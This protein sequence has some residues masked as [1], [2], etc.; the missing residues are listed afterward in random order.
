VAVGSYQCHEDSSRW[1]EK[2]ISAEEMFK[3]IKEGSGKHYF[4]KVSTPA[5]WPGEGKKSLAGFS[6]FNI[7]VLSEIS[8]WHEIMTDLVL[9]MLPEHYGSRLFLTGFADKNFLSPE[10][11]YHNA[12]FNLSREIRAGPCLV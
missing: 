1:P 10:Q 4:V 8:V 3:A 5:V 11:D 2:N 12:A 7:P 6:A 9:F